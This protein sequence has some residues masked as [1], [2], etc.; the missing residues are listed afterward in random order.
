ME[1]GQWKDVVIGSSPCEQTVAS[2]KGF[3]N[4]FRLEAQLRD[5]QTVVEVLS[6]RPRLS[7]GG[8]RPTG[9][10]DW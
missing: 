7:F 6:N 5:A 3:F 2:C 8:E 10:C 4:K 9:G 1:R